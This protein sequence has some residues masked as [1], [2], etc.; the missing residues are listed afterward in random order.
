MDGEKERLIELC[1]SENEQMRK[2]KFDRMTKSEERK[3]EERCAWQCVFTAEGKS[4]CSD[5]ASSDPTSS[6]SVFWPV[7]QCVCVCVCEWEERVKARMEREKKEGRF[8]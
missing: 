4:L 2:S 3:S 7:P 1:V 6:Q 5:P 8:V